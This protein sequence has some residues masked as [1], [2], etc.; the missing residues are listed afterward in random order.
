MLIE[1]AASLGEE[2]FE[3]IYAFNMHGRLAKYN[4][5]CIAFQIKTLPPSVIITDKVEWEF[6]N[7]ES[8]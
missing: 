1:Y 8:G 6:W 7:A 4:K 3:T 5:L 2:V